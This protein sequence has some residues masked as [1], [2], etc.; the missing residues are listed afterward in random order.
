[1]DQ[2]RGQGADPRIPGS[3]RLQQLIEAELRQ[4]GRAEQTE[5]V[6]F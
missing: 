2:T 3:Q 6:K 4:R 5:H 1:M